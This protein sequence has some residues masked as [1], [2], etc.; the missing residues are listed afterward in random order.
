MFESSDLIWGDI[1]ETAR[2]F[3][4]RIKLLNVSFLSE[5]QKLLEVLSSESLC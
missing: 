1:L 5:V 3:F 2:S 4:W